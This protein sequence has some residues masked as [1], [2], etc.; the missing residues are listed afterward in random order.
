MPRAAIDIGSNSLL[1][2]VQDEDGRTLHDEA[3]V[4]GL[5]RGLGDRGLFRPDRLE[6]ANAVLADYARIAEALG[7]PPGEIRAVA[8]SA[9]RRALN[10]ATFIDQLRRQTGISVQIIDGPTE[11]GLTWLGAAQGLSL[12]PGLLAVID[13]GGG[14]TELVLGEDGLIA[15]RRSLEIGTV[16]LTDELLDGGAGMIRPVDLARLRARVEESFAALS[17][18][19]LPRA[20]VAVAG[21][22]T[23][24]A[25][26]ELGLSAWD[27][28]R[29]HGSRLSRAALR[30]WIDRLVQADPS[31]RR[32]LAAVSPERADTLLAGAVILEAACTAAHRESMVVSDGGVRHGLLLDSLP[33]HLE[34]SWGAG[35][36]QKT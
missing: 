35:P 32:L 31:E 33:G 9:T 30:R 3:R 15:S 19:R 5:G 14:S 4:V 21:T 8:T 25:A 23:S 13:T 26:M 11:A 34:L 22:A 12:P 10:A 17:W 24:L 16:R 36:L 28:D 29:V 1:L 6:A 18:P 7:V 2:I 27:R 20:L